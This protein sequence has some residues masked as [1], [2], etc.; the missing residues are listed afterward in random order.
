MRRMTF[1]AAAGAVAVAVGMIS[2]T[3]GRTTV[4]KPVAIVIPTKVAEPDLATGTIVSRPIP[5]QSSAQ[6][7]AFPLPT[8]PEAFPS[9][10][11]SMPPPQRARSARNRM[12]S[13]SPAS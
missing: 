12:R 10:A 7:I 4:Q 6:S 8:R 5:A 3:L 9:P 11:V 2:F 1:L 13:G